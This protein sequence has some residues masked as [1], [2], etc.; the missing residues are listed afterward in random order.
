[1]VGKRESEYQFLQVQITGK[2]ELIRLWE[3]C[4]CEFERFTESARLLAQI[5]PLLIEKQLLSR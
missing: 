2:P 3:E 5:L 4:H 1:V